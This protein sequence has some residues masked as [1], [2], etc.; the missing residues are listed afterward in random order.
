MSSI[1]IVGAGLGGLVLAC[2]LHRQGVTTTVYEAE[3]SAAARTQ[4]DLLDIHSH[5][6]QAALRD[7]G[8]FDGFRAL[9]RPGHDAKRITDRAGTIVFDW[10]GSPLGTRPE[11]DRGELRSMLIASLPE[12]TIRWG[13]KA[14]GVI[15]TPGRRPQVNFVGGSSIT[16]D[17]VVGADGAWSKVRRSVSSVAPVYTG[18]CFVKVGSAPGQL[19]SREG[20][21]LIG[22]GTL[23]AVAPGQGIL[24]HH[25][26]DGTLSGYVAINAP[27]ELMTSVDTGDPSGMRAMI[28]RRFENWAPALTALAFDNISDP[29]L[30]PIYALPIT[31]RWERVPGVTL[32]G[33]AAHLMSPFAG[34]GANLAM[35]DGA[36]LAAE[37][38]AHPGHIEEAL[39]AYEDALFPRSAEV[40]QR[41]ASNLQQFF[42]P[43]APRS[44]VDLFA[45]LLT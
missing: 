35:F 36:A 15:T 20:A 4:G 30:R 1:A 37:I 43:D 10:P 25:N 33:D 6:G 8:V 44:A 16:A 31:H 26:A 39:S 3:E 34:E 5:T 40:A 27:L 42:G 9:I 18:T 41:S 13:R 29:V 23:M 21:A 38:V 24:A 2:T 11:V 7:A 45:G 28:K 32:I 17:L 19:L 12:G 22:R 14:I